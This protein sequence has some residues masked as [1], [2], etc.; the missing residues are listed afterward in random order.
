VKNWLRNRS[1]ALYGTLVKAR[2]SDTVRYVASRPFYSRD[3]ARQSRNGRYFAF[4]VCGACGMGAVLTHTVLLLKYAER[5][6]QIPVIAFTNPLYGSVAGADWFPDYFAMTPVYQ[7]GDA[8]KGRLNYLK[9]HHEFSAAAFGVPQRISLAEANSVFSRYITIKSTVDDIVASV[10]AGTPNA[11]YDLSVHYR[12]TDKTLE[13]TTASF[14][15]VTAKIESLRQDGLRVE[16]VFLA[17]DVVDFDRYIRN[18]YPAIEFHDFNVLPLEQGPAPR[19]FS[20][21]N[22]RDKAVEALVNIVAHS[23]SRV[24]IR[25]CSYLSAWSK[26]LNPAM[27]TCTLNRPYKTQVFPEAE[28]VDAERAA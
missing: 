18:R 25:T 15:D 14:D 17:T 28:I 20:A 12:G 3:R 11:P 19:H 5:T 2:H 7:I 26:I 1:P 10:S 24:C 6:D 13:A 4:D 22:G 27:K 21:I 23:R 9:I 8:T 16:K